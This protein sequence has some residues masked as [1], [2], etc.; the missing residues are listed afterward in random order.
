MK[1]III[2]SAMLALL[3]SCS[4]PVRISPLR[5]A[6]SNEWNLTRKKFKDEK[7]SFKREIKTSWFFG[8]TTR[9]RLDPFFEE[10]G[11]RCESITSLQVEVSEEFSDVLSS[12][13]L[14]P[15][16][17]LT[18]SGTH[19]SSDSDDRVQSIEIMED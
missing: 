9:V 4:S 17:Q 12:I 1:K 15:S 3:L 11:I 5:C 10:Q 6:N 18:V 16:K 14:F 2:C 7:F 19:T 13:F 8:E